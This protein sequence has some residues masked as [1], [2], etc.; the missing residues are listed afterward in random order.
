[1]RRGRESRMDFGVQRTR[2]RLWYSW[3]LGAGGK[4][5]GRGFG[6]L[7]KS[8]GGQLV[9]LQ[10]RLVGERVLRKVR[11]LSSQDERSQDIIGAGGEDCGPIGRPR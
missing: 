3:A 1:M 7:G 9:W 10:F 8:L 11:R 5:K 4:H 2:G 6:V